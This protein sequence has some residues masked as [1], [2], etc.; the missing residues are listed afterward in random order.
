MSCK[1]Q[2]L[3]TLTALSRVMSS[4]SP[5]S[6]T[7]V[8][9]RFRIISASTATNSTSENLRPGQFCGP[10]DHG[11]YVFLAGV[12][13][14]SWPLVSVVSQRDGFHVRESGQYLGCV[15][16]AMQFGLMLV[17][18][19][20]MMVRLSMVR[21]WGEGLVCFGRLGMGGKRRRVSYCVRLVSVGL[22]RRGEMYE[23]G[24]ATEEARVDGGV[25]P[26]A[27]SDRS[28]LANFFGYPVLHFWLRCK[29]CHAKCERVGCRV[30]SGKVC[31][32]QLLSVVSPATTY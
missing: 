21:R 32:S 27:H 2:S 4:L 14:L 15:W 3:A 24:A 26:I 20:M 5:S 10:S 31:K 16:T 13:R 7:T 17:F 30:M 28:C 1:S 9:T 18:G 19:G 11:K 12:T 25:V 23:Y 22:V 8:N 6:F 29:K